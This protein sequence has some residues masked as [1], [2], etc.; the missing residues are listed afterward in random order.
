MDTRNDLP[1]G[2]QEKIAN[3]LRELTAQFLAREANR[4][5]LLTVTSTNVSADLKKGTVYISVLP[6][7]AEKAALDF[8]KRQRSALRDHLKK[9]METKSVPFLDFEIDY[10]EKNRQRIDE[11]LRE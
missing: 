2:R 7:S 5:S 8:C 10:G 9:N 3:L 1:T 11:L 4:T 6:A